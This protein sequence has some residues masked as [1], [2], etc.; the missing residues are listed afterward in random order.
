M[1]PIT[2]NNNDL[3]SLGMVSNMI[4]GITQTLKQDG[5]GGL[6]AGYYVSTTHRPMLIVFMMIPY[7]IMICGGYCCYLFQYL[8]QDD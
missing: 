5:I 1:Q 6:F 4:E 3:F 2:I 7:N 8:H